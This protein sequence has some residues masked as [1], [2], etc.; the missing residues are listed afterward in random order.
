MKLV[1]ASHNKDKVKEIEDLLAPLGTSVISAKALNLPEPEE[2]GMTFAENA[3]IKSE[4][5]ARLSNHYALADDSGLCVPAL[6]GAPGIY[7]ARWAGKDKD[8]SVAMER[9]RREL[10]E[11]KL[12]PTGQN[13]YFICAIAL[14]SPEGK[15]EIFEGRIDGKLTFPPR[16]TKGFGYDPIF[17]PEGYQRTFGEIDMSEKHTMS[18]RARALAKFAA[19]LK[20]TNL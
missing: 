20:G 13:A 1:I 14:T 18:H 8:F 15:T 11:K 12:N 16:G 3:A 6:G 9:V 5:A 4:T 7:S 17:I 2:T 19:Y 10:E